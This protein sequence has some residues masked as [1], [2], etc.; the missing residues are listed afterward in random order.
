[1]YL[2]FYDE[3]E[4][5]GILGLTLGPDRYI[6]YRIEYCSSS[7]FQSTGHQIPDE[8]GNG[9][10]WTI[11]RSPA[12]ITVYYFDTSII[13]IVFDEVRSRYCEDRLASQNRLRFQKNDLLSTFYRTKPTGK[14]SD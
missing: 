7:S 6:K 4:L 9:A 1:M 10:A 13:Y 12:S 2:R 14:L 5:D 3:H 8:A 11:Y